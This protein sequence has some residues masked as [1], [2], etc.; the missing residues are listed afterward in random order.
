MFAAR[1]PRPTLRP[2]RRNDER[3]ASTSTTSGD[4]SRRT[5]REVAAIPQVTTFRT[6]DCTELQAFREELG[7]LAAAGRARGAL[8]D[9]PPRI[10]CS[11]PD[12]PRTT[13]SCGP[14]STSAIATDTERGLMIPVLQDAGAR[15]I[16]EPEGGDRP[17]GR[18]RPRRARSRWRTSGRPRRS[19][20]PTPAPTAPRRAPRCS[21]PG[22]AVT[23]A[24]GVI[25]PRALVV[26]G[27]VVARPACDAVAHV[28]SP[29]ARRR[30]GRPRADR[31]GRPVAVGGPPARLAA[32]KIVVP[33]A[34]GD[35]DRVRAR[36]RRRPRRA[37]PTSAT[38]PPTPSRSR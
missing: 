5:S 37:S 38:T 26:D 22:C 33:A 7:R 23:L 19:G 35:R 3:H 28:R 4:R 6:V 18:R 2:S 34:V 1:Q 27:A 32:M 36:A 30:D 15:G 8:P 29:G 13:S 9:D 25:Q 24:F 20:S 11:T 21:T 31:S 12:G 17:A 14:R 16:A 10:R